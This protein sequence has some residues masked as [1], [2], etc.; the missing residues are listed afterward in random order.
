MVLARCSTD[1]ISTP[2]MV[3]LFATG[4]GVEDLDLSL[5]GA[6]LAA[7]NCLKVKN[8]TQK[9]PGLTLRVLVTWGFAVAQSVPGS[10]VA[11]SAGSSRGGLILEGLDVFQVNKAD[12]QIKEMKR[13]GGGGEG[14]IPPSVYRPAHGGELP[15]FLSFACWGKLNFFEVDGPI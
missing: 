5:L 10:A 9:T 6:M 15:C 11:G 2:P 3:S 14:M 13:G 8:S 1:P 4:A 12:C 7:H